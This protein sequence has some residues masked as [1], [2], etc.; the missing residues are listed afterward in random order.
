MYYEQPV[1]K[2]Y[3]RFPSQNSIRDFDEKY[4]YPNR[5]YSSG[6]HVRNSSRQSYN[7]FSREPVTKA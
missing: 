7:E 3:Y 4:Y 2:T 1:K 6:E 5:L